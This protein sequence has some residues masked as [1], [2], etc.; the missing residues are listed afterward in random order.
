MFF[1][2]ILLQVFFSFNLEEFITISYIRIEELAGVKK[3]EIS[4]NQKQ[5]KNKGKTNLKNETSKMK[6]FYFWQVY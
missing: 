6:M 3:K 5:N 1:R 2:L 4:R